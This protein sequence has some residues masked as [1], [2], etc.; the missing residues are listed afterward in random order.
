[1]FI[2]KKPL[3]NLQTTLPASKNLPSLLWQVLLLK[4]EPLRA[5]R[6]ARLSLIITGLILIFHF[7]FLASFFSRLPPE[8]PLYYSRPWGQAQLVTPEQFLILPVFSLTVFLINTILALKLHPQE[9][10]L[11]RLA[12]WTSLVINFTTAFTL[13]KIVTLVT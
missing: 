13:F 8:L 2:K 6:S 9:K 5:D 7:S 3:F 4:T 10:I 12:L 11:A 1:M